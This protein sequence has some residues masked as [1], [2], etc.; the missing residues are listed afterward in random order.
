[1]SDGGEGCPAC[2]NKLH[3]VRVKCNVEPRAVGRAHV[4]TLPPPPLQVWTPND[5]SSGYYPFT[6]NVGARVHSDSWGSSMVTYD[7]IAASVDRFTWRRQDF[8][9]IFAAGEAGLPSGRREWKAALC[10][11]RI[12]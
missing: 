7:A 4:E 3:A 9:P 1:L 6:Y 11:S 10:F 8:L 12:H 2:Q 5:L